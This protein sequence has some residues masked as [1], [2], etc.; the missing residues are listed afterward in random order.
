MADSLTV[1]SDNPYS[2]IM[3]N[4]LGSPQP[5][6]Q[7][8]DAPEQQSVAPAQPLQAPPANANENPYAD[9]MGGS[10]E[11]VYGAKPRPSAGAAFL[12]GAL[13]SV[14]PSAG[15][16]AAGA[17]GAEAGAVFGLPGAIGG[18]VVGMVAGQ[19]AVSTVQ[20]WAVS[21]L[22]KSWQEALG[23]TEEQKQSFEKEHPLAYYAGGLAPLPSQ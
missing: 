14:L 4:S 5:S 16:I 9:I 22:P 15:A 18:A 19:K 17:T 20:N 7:S 1:G 8:E 6:I 13:E 11:D 2:K 21:K 3:G 12:G 10:I 23:Q